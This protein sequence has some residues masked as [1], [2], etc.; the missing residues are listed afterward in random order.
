[1]SFGIF[2]SEYHQNI[3]LPFGLRKDT[4]SHPIMP[5][6]R[7]SSAMMCSRD[8]NTTFPIATIPLGGLPLDTAG[9]L[10]TSRPARCNTGC[11]DTVRQSL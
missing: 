2:S 4:A 8:V 9:L 11:S 1:M 3:R 5:L 6:P 7:A 10:P